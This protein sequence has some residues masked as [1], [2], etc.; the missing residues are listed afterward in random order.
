[1][2][3]ASPLAGAVGLDAAATR[4]RGA[5]AVA[6][7]R[8]L[9]AALGGARSLAR[10]AA[11]TLAGHADAAGGGAASLAADLELAALAGRRI[12]LD[13]A[14]GGG[15]ATGLTVGLGAHRRA[16]LRRLDVDGQR[17]AGLGLHVGD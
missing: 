10:A 8:T 4:R 7:A 1:G 13:V 6:L 16:A 12:R 14:L 9:D 11:A 5:G 2:A 15:R 17:P 3:G